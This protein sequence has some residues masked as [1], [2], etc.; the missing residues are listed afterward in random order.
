MGN[1][2]LDGSIP[3][4]TNTEGAR[5]KVQVA[6]LANKMWKLLITSF[7]IVLGY[8]KTLTPFGTN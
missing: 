6:L 8:K 5:V 7:S 3:W 1:F 4:L 2:G